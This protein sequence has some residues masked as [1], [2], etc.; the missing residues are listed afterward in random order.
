MRLPLFSALLFLLLTPIALQAQWELQDAHTTADLRGI[1]SLGNGVAWASGTNGTVLRTEDAGFVWQLCAIPPNAE[2]LDFRGIQAFDNN[3]A[4]VM[5]SGKGDLSRLYKTTD[6][7]QTWHLLFTNPDKD[8]FW[9]A[10]V[11]GR[12]RAAGKLINGTVVGDPVNGRYTLFSFTETLAKDEG[13]TSFF[14]THFPVDTRCRKPGYNPASLQMPPEPCDNSR[15]DADFEKTPTPERDEGIFAASNSNLLTQ[16]EPGFVTGGASGSFFIQFRP[17][18]TSPGSDYIRNRWLK[19]ALPL[20]RSTSAGA[21]SMTASQG[22]NL[23]VVGGDYRDPSASEG[24]ATFSTDLGQH[25][26]PATTPPHGYRSAV[27]Y[28]PTHNT[29]ITVGPN[30][31]DISTD[32][33]RNW[34][35]PQTGSNR[36]ARRRPALERPLAPLRRRSRTGASAI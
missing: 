34:R 16:G 11:A 33:G 3:T 24:T 4:I 17:Q 22:R 13:G 8:G 29:W 26:S 2:H 5:S 30:G 23:V 18:P 14:R 9:D 10:M 32:D 19:I 36:P 27:T 12:E 7:C 25:W 1:D 15:S 31:T 20:A 28:D 35:R 21:F 6:G